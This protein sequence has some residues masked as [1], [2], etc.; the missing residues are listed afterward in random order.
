MPGRP[1]LNPFEAT[2]FW[3]GVGMA[4]RRWHTRPAYRLL[5]FWLG[6]LMM[7]AWLSR[8]SYVP[9]FLRMM[10][11]TPAAYLLTGV[12]VWEA[13]RFLRERYFTGE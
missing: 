6:V 8:D 1:L 7:A 4:L 11:A 3:L 9:H 12:G 10:G 2:F 5:L 13:F